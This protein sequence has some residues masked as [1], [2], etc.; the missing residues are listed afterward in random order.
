MVTKTCRIP[1]MENQKTVGLSKFCVIYLVYFHLS[2]Q[3]DTITV[4]LMEQISRKIQTGSCLRYTWCEIRSV[5]MKNIETILV[6][7]LLT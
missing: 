2:K 5:K 3:F 6:S 1:I 4:N 7:L